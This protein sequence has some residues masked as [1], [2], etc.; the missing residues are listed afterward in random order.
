MTGTS[1]FNKIAIRFVPVESHFRKNALQQIFSDSDSFVPKLMNLSFSVKY[2]WCS[3]LILRFSCYVF[4]KANRTLET[5]HFVYP[6]LI[7]C[8]YVHYRCFF[9]MQTH[10][11]HWCQVRKTTEKTSQNSGTRAGNRQRLD[12][13]AGGN[14]LKTVLTFK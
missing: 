13:L 7:N 8:A 14:T 11:F 3:L 9:P 5:I 10:L 4:W 2:L 1:C 6:C 12:K